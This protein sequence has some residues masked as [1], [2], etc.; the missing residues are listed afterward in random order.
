MNLV[1]RAICTATTILVIFYSAP[2]ISADMTRREAFVTYYTSDKQA[3]YGYA[4]RYGSW[5]I[6]FGEL[7][8][9]AQEYVSQ[10]DHGFAL[11]GGGYG[12]YTIDGREY[13]ADN[14]SSFAYSW[15]LTQPAPEPTLNQRRLARIADMSYKEARAEIL[16]N[17]IGIISTR[18]PNDIGREYCL[19]T[20]PDLTPVGPVIVGGTAARHDYV[21][22]GPSVN[23]RYGHLR[24]GQRVMTVDGVAWYWVA[25]VTDSV[26]VSMGHRGGPI[27]IAL[28]PKWL[29]DDSC[30]L[31]DD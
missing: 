10:R 8:W 17:Y 21:P 15:L 27:L 30:L 22:Y 5:D 1:L 11:I 9:E 18:S 13:L 12:Y 19:F 29:C 6:A 31:V 2:H 25:D 24:L 3:V 23:D 26:L 7:Y 16:S 14:R 4:T 20:A 28:G